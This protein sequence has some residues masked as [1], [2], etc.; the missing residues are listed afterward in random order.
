M[1]SNLKEGLQLVEIG[2]M[3]LN[4]H[5]KFIAKSGIYYVE[6]LGSR[7]GTFINDNPNPINEEHQLSDGDFV[8]LGTEFYFK[9]DIKLAHN[10]EERKEQGKI[11]KKSI[12]RRFKDY[13]T[14]RG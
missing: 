7:N 5:C 4:H 9:V 13:I 6:D 14:R 12:F 1:M 8:Y 3:S 2:I 11:P 10:E